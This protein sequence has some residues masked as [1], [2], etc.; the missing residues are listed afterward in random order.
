MSLYIIII[1][2]SGF[3]FSS[4]CDLSPAYHPCIGKGA[5]FGGDLMTS[6]EGATSRSVLMP[7]VVFAGG[8]V[9]GAGVAIRSWRV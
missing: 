4:S 6:D 8:F 1:C 9:V 3:T 5:I 2:A 7:N